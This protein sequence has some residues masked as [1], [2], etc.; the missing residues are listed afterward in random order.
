MIDLV[1][2]IWRRLAVGDATPLEALLDPGFVA[3]DV[4]TTGLNVRRDAVVAVRSA[5]VSLRA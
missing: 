4:E 5:T 3:I 1:T 2:R